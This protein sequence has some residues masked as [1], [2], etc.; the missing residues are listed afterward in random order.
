MMEHEQF[1]SN[2][3]EALFEEIMDEFA[4]RLNE[5]YM[6]KAKLLRTDPACEFPAKLEKRCQRIIRQ[7]CLER[8]ARRY[9]AYL[10]GFL[11]R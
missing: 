11:N 5:K 9:L 6:E 1:P 8:R 10:A 3:E 7:K 4:K 2:C